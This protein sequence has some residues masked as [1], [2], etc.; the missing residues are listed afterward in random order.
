MT[1][2]EAVRRCQEGDREAFRHLVEAYKSPM[3][4][5]ALLMTGNPALAEEH[6]QDALLNAWRG[7]R[8]FQRGRPVKPWL[9]RIL[10]NAVVSQQRRRSFTTVSLDESLPVGAPG[11]DT[12]TVENRQVLREALSQLQFNSETR[13]YVAN[14]PGGWRCEG[15]GSSSHAV[16]IFEAMRLVELDARPSCDLR[17]SWRT[18]GE[19]A[20]NDRH[21]CVGDDSALFAAA[22]DMV[23][24]TE[25]KASCRRADAER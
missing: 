10:V 5:T 22:D 19:V 14:R 11:D 24:A 1:D 9:M 15:R 21:G 3:Y 23:E 12:E 18:I 7:I 25:R 6:V 16:D 2:D 4:G 8:R 17:A 13:R 20:G